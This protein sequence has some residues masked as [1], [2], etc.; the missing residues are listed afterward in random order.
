MVINDLDHDVE[1]L[2]LEDLPDETPETAHYII[3]QMELNKAGKWTLILNIQNANSTAARLYFLHCSPSRLP[4]SSDP[5]V[6]E[7]AMQDIQMTLRAWYTASQGFRSS[8]PS[9]HLVLTMDVCYK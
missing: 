5:S 8:N 4:L 9:H 1:E 7:E 2:V 3:Q 6:R